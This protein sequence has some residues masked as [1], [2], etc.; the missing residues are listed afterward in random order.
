V[1]L[2]SGRSDGIRGKLLAAPWDDWQ[3]WPAHRAEMEGTDFFT[4]RR[5]VPRD[6]GLIWQ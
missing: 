5:I 6:R 1:F 2:L 3:N 4:L